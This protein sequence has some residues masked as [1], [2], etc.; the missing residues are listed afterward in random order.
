MFNK[1]SF[2]PTNL[3]V[4]LAFVLMATFGSVLVAQAGTSYAG[5]N[6]QKD[7]TVSVQTGWRPYRV[8]AGD[9]LS[10]LAAEAKVTLET[11]IAAN[12]LKSDQINTGDLVLVPTQVVGTAGSATVAPTDDRA[13]P[14]LLQVI[15]TTTD[16]ATVN[17]V[18][19]EE[20]VAPQI[21]SMTASPLNTA[22]AIVMAILGL[23]VMAMVFFALR[24]RADDSPVVHSVFGMMGNG[25]FLFAG[26]LIGVILFPM[27]RTPSLMALPT[28]VSA[29]IAVALIALLVAKELF[30][31]G[32]Q[33]RTMNRLLNLGIAPL[34]MI[35]FLMVA[36][37]VAGIVN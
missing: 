28:A 33:W 1:L 19:L 20:S 3:F 36:T 17:V 16:L 12:C 14:T 37:R 29:T 4:L 10:A 2:Q 9:T 6:Q 15:S 27:L 26:V 21:V 30:F 8:G 24:P 34:L 31:S 5:S 13:A 11:L 23:G 18:A 32:Q 35:F 7:C 22:N 25:I